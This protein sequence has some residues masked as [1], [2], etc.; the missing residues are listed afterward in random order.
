MKQTQA[1]PI[2][3]LDSGLGGLTVLTEL[4]RCLPE[5]DFIYYGDAAN[6]PYGG[7]PAEEIRRLTLENAHLLLE[8]LQAKAL[9]VACNTATS[10]A[11]DQIRQ[12]YPDRPVI[13]MEP[14]L[15]PA[16]LSGEHPKVLVM[17]TPV[18]LR[19]N[20]FHRLLDSYEG[21]AEVFPLP[22][23]GLVELIENGI[24]EG[25]ELDSLLSRLL[26]GTMN[27]PPDAVVLGCT[28]YP[29][30]EQAIR[31]AIGTP[32]QIFQGGPGTARETRRRLEEAGLR[33]PSDGRSGSVCFHSSLSGSEW[34][35]LAQ[36]LFRR[37]QAR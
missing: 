32:V 26:P 33:R 31:K 13:G 27:P 37:A 12:Q 11:I 14:A 28:H 17:A 20:K 6:A 3:V 2:G 16:A 4:V 10:V 34:T 35:Q 9:V 24:L 7:K 5:E 8:E 22:C 30:V 23:P 18:T 29:L 15:K 19:E 36:S 21:Q 1:A 25:P